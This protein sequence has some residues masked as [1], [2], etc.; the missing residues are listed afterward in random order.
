MK[1]HLWLIIGAVV[2]VA[3]I[4]VSLI[5]VLT[6]NEN[7][8]E[9]VIPDLSGDWTAVATY[10]GDVPTYTDGQYAAFKDGVAYF[11]KDGQLTTPYAE[12]AYTINEAFQLA[13]PDIGR[14]YKV[15]KKT[16]NVV[17]L[18]QDTNTY[19]LLVRSVSLLTQTQ[20]QG[21]WQV[22]MKGEQMH[23]GESLVFNG[24]KL[25]YYKAG[26]ATPAATADYVVE[27]GVLK[28]AALG[29][30]MRC[31]PVGPDTIVLVEKNG[32]VWELVRE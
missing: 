13:L 2:A 4:V 7:E 15:D 8:P 9:V 11:Y 6:P 19:M 17:R 3:A 28:A 18:Y 27:N 5:F 10:V 16:D 25:E 23:N 24:S 14:E 26:S 20:S 12:S 1:K 31:Y 32:I 30:E 21:K 22:K 29:M